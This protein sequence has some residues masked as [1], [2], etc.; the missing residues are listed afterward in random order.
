MLTLFAIPKPFNGHTAV[1][2]ENAVR[3]WVALGDACRVILFGNEHG[4]ASVAGSLGVAHV[5]TVQRNKYGTPL[6]NDLFDQ[7]HRLTGDR[8]LCYINADILLMNDFFCSVQRVVRRKRRFLMVGQRWDLDQDRPIQFDDLWQ[9]RLRDRTR[10]HGVLRDPTA[11]DYFLFTSGLWG[12]VPP[13]AIGRTA[14]DNWLIHRACQLR[15]PVIDATES[16]MAVHQNHDYSHAG[17]G[18]NWIWRGPEARLNRALAGGQTSCFTIWDS[19][20]VLTP[21]GLHRRRQTGLGGGIWSYRRSVRLG[22]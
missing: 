21:D 17:T 15:V 5:P 11:I 7:A 14:F 4:T 2:Q 8:Y 10:S 16:V 1:I 22:A 9:T 6:L 18:Y 12:K 3:S 13:F 20:H 19:T